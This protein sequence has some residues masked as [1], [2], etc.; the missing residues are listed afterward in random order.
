[1]PWQYMLARFCAAYPGLFV[2]PAHPTRDK[3]IPAPWFDVLYEQLDAVESARQMRDANAAAH[4]Q[5]LAM[6][7]KD[8]EVKAF[9]RALHRRAFPVKYRRK[10]RPEEHAPRG[11]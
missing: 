10:P 7:G 11:E 2:S 9:T 3:V 1:V 8:P 4:G 5:A 6:A